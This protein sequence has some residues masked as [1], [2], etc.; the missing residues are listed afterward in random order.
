MLRN[1]ENYICTKL[2]ATYYTG[3][4]HRDQDPKPKSR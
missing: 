2:Y 4:I 1:K 3:Y